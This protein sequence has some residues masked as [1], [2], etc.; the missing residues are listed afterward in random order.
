[1]INLFN[2]MTNQRRHKKIGSIK[3]SDDDSFLIVKPAM[4]S[5]SKILFLFLHNFYIE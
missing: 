1:M 3:H 2:G 5:G 4:F